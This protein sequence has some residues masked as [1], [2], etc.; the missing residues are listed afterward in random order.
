MLCRI[1]IVDDDDLVVH[2]LRREL[3]RKPEVGTD[4]VEIETYTDTKSAL[5]RAAEPEGYFDVA[6]VDYHM[7]GMDGVLFLDRL[8]RLQPEAV[9]IL[10]TGLMDMDGAIAAINAAR[11]DHLI[12]KPW[13]EYDLKGRI[14]LALRQREL[15]RD[16]QTT[17]QAVTASTSYRLL[18][19]DDDE[20]LLKALEREISAQGHATRGPHPLFEIGATACP[21]LALEQAASSC[22]DIVIADYAMPKMDGIEFLNRLRASCPHC[23]RILMSGRADIGVLTDAIN[24]AQIYHFIG[25][26]W[27]APVLRAALAEALNY[28]DLLRAS[29]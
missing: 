26:P 15:R 2:A 1:L 8:R 3:L 21:L 17:A 7:K 28:R 9:R 4:G 5:D 25:K 27:D 14:A 18:L 29:A 22:P 12:I 20:L 11:I 13:Q 23:V 19:V 6:I 10:L 16:S 24:I